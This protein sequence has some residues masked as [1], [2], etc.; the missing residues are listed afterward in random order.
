MLPVAFIFSRVY[1]RSPQLWPLAIIAA[2]LMLASVVW[3]YPS[4]LKFVRWPWRGL[5][6]LLRVAAV[7]V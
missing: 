7:L 1:W 4:Q 2:A 5:L 3:L 6:P